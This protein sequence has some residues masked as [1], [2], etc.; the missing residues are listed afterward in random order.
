M[1]VLIL[2]G[3]LLLAQLGLYFKSRGK[4]HEY[5]EPLDKKEYPL[6]A[7]LPVGLY[8]L[9]R[10]RYSFDTGYDKRLLNKLSE[11]SGARYASYYL[12]I[13]WA[14]KIAHIMVGLLVVFFIGGI[15]FLPREK[16][17]NSDTP[18]LTEEGEIS[19][20]GFGAGNK[21]IELEAKIQK[22][23]VERVERFTIPV[24]ELPPVTEDEKILAE[25]KEELTWETFRGRNKD[26]GKITEA[27]DFPGNDA[28]FGNKGVIISWESQSPGIISGKGEVTRPPYGEGDKTFQIRALLT[29]GSS[30]PA[31]KYFTVTVLSSDTPVSDR[32]MVQAAIDKLTLLFG[33]KGAGP[34]EEGNKTVQLPGAFEKLAGVT[35]KWLRPK[36]E[37]GQDHTGVSF[38]VFGIFAVGAVAF[39]FDS[40]VNKKVRQRRLML[41]LDF[42]DFLNK[43]TLLIN[44]GMTVGKAWEKIV[45]D[46]KKNGPLYEELSLALSEIRAGKG[47]KYAYEDF[48]K[49]CKV[50]EITKF[51]SMVLQN[52]RK[53]NSELVGMLKAQADS[54]WEMRKHAAK[55][56][57]EEAS[58]KMLLPMMIMFAAILIIVAL[59]AVMALQVA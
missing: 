19:R 41:E 48:A 56:L 12:R 16:S 36:D 30:G 24:P 8:L 17:I 50:L 10:L 13:H 23:E 52:M 51:V 5:L 21:K 42:P 59:P 57:G 43:L 49:R 6:K 54:C 20:P 39:A 33:K 15:L 2:F 31:A 4:F 28:A 22:G 14:N 34:V 26:M 35:I 32:Q 11:I 45:A 18:R 3:I 47:E 46:N 38:L 37:S 58:T 27:L 7:L 44:A 29:K 25:A 53:G 9:D 1:I 40:N 55:R